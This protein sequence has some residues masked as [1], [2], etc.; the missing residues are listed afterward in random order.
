MKKEFKLSEKGFFYK[1][2]PN[3]GL[4]FY[5]KDVKKFIELLKE[6]LIEGFYKNMTC[7]DMMRIID[8]RTG[9]LK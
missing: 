3:V 5:Y 9:D 4:H 1:E 2:K 8:K 7:V 6:D